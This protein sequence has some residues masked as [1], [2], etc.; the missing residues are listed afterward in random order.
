[1]QEMGML[2]EFKCEMYN[3]FEQGVFLL[4]WIG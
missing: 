3:I 1:M 2:Q 4:S